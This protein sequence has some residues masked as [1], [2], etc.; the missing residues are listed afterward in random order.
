MYLFIAEKVKGIEG[1]RVA[2]RFCFLGCI[3][4][5]RFLLCCLCCSELLQVS[6][7]HP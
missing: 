1:R 6:G 5:L 4:A 7:C 2:A 3:A